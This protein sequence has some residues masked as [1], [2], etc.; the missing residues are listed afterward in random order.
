M[1]TYI[2]EYLNDDKRRSGERA[3]EYDDQ[4]GSNDEIWARINTIY[5]EGS[6][7][8]GDGACYN[9][10]HVHVFYIILQREYVYWRSSRGYIL[11]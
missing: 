6:W 7:R 10:D 2:Y 11:S 9:G 3:S 8:L 4:P 1:Y 5:L